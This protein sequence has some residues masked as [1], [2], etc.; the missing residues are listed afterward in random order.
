MP[1]I[2]SGTTSSTYVLSSNSGDSTGFKWYDS[3]CLGENLGVIVFLTVDFLE[4]TF[5]ESLASLSFEL[6]LIALVFSI[7]I[8]FSL[9][10]FY[11]KGI[12]DYSFEKASDSLI[13]PI[14]DSFS[15]ALGFFT[16]VVAFLFAY[17]TRCL[18]FPF[19]T[20]PYF[21]EDFSQSSDLSLGMFS[22]IFDELAFLFLGDFS[23]FI[24]LSFI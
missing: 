24:L 20:F 22:F 10:I 8:L 2:A 6:F 17:L 18:V 1:L 14:V 11:S 15:L 5:F 4:E 12:S 9:A 23:G 16:G 3:T 7:T 21:N 13:L 19:E